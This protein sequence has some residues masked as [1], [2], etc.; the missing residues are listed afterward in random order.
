MFRGIFFSRLRRTVWCGGIH[1]TRPCCSWCAGARPTTRRSRGYRRTARDRRPRSS[2]R[3]ADLSERRPTAR[4][5]SSPDSGTVTA[6]RKAPIPTAGCTYPRIR[7][8]SLRASPSASPCPCAPRSGFTACSALSWTNSMPTATRSGC[9]GTARLLGGQRGAHCRAVRI[10]QHG[11]LYPPIPRPNG[12]NAHRL[13]KK[14]IENRP[15][16]SARGRSIF[17]E[18]FRTAFPCGRSP[19]CTAPRSAA[20]RRFSLWKRGA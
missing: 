17:T 12:N 7:R 10:Q 1:R 2:R 5:C 13:P 4:C 14:Q 8:C 16:A 9:G 6:R 18:R 20:R 3:T 19:P 11:T 15:Q